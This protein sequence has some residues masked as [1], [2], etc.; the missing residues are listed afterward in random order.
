VAALPLVQP[1][2]AWAAV[3]Y[4]GVQKAFVQLQVVLS[5]VERPLESVGMVEAS[6]GQTQVVRQRFLV[7]I[8]AAGTD[9]C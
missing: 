2:P 8:Q 6:V 1:D 3:V 4:L 5:A 7:G 9:K